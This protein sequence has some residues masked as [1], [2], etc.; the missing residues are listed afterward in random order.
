MLRPAGMV[1]EPE[2]E[3]KGLGHTCIRVIRRSKGAE[4]SLVLGQPGL[5]RRPCSQF[6]PGNGGVGGVKELAPE[7]VVRRGIVGRKL[8]Y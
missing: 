2:F 5:V 8:A 3:V 7:R 6:C 4:A 1:V